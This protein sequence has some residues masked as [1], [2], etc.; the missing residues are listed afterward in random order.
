[1]SRWIVRSE[2]LPGSHT[3]I[4][5]YGILAKEFT[6]TTKGRVPFAAVNVLS[7]DSGG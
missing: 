4:P 6:D 7:L 1:M 2:W 3:T 5:A